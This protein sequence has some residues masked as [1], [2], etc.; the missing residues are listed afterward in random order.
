MAR[1]EPVMG[2]QTLSA[3][4]L[5]ATS[6]K[7]LG[8]NLF[9]GGTMGWLFLKNLRCHLQEPD[10]PL[11]IGYFVGHWAHTWFEPVHAAPEAP[12]R[13]LNSKHNTIPGGDLADLNIPVSIKYRSLEKPGTMKHIHPK[14]ERYTYGSNCPRWKI[15]N[16]V[17]QFLY[18]WV[19]QN[20]TEYHPGPVLPSMV[21]HLNAWMDE[22]LELAR[23]D[24][25]MLR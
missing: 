7:H 3:D 13:S 17:S 18:F 16:F 1:F 23:N 12:K 25:I 6:L 20:V 8:C 10:V 24:L 19:V 2:G 22:H 4:P 11:T 21:P 15:V 5:N 14:R 9:H